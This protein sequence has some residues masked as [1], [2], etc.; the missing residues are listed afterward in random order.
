[1]T[2]EL[3][4]QS[5]HGMQHLTC[6]YGTGG[7][8]TGQLCD[9]RLQLEAAYLSTILNS[10][11]GIATNRA[12]TGLTMAGKLTSR[13]LLRS[14]ALRRQPSGLNKTWPC[15]IADEEGSPTPK[16]HSKT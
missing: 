15:Q 1:M 8:E 7:N 3:E 5:T 13:S 2:V 16:A 4:R 14:R 6:T 9:Q 12:G 11:G 10:T